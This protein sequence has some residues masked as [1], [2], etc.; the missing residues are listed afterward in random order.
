MEIPTTAKEKDMS[1]W[2]YTETELW[3]HGEDGIALYHVF[4]LVSFGRTVLAFA[5]A[6]RGE[7]KDADDPHDIAMRRSEDGGRSFAP[8]VT[9]IPSEGRRCLTNPTPLFDA[10]TGKLFLFYCENFGNH[11][12]ENYVIESADGGRTWSAP[13]ALTAELNA[14][15]APLAF[16]LFGPGH[17]TQLHGAYGGRLIVPV[18]H[19]RGTDVPKAERDY[20]AS[21]LLSDDHG[22]TWRQTAP[23]TGKAQHV[24]EARV[25]QT[26]DGS[27]LWA[28]RASGSTC[29]FCCRSTDGGESWSAP[30]PMPV[31][32][33]VGCDAGLAALSGKAGYEDLVVLSRI[34]RT[35]RR[36]DMELLYSK[37]GGRSFAGRMTLPTGDAMPGYSD[38]TVL[39]DEA[40]TLGL[41]HCRNNHV[42]FSRISLQTLT[43]GAYEG[44]KRSVWLW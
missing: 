44:T 32:P 9:L 1:L 38:L 17:G 30:A 4:G 31:S 42:L 16:H 8:S 10:Q 19:R 43:G 2:E 22:A 34:S 37:D 29:R 18:W 35:D 36:M 27:L 39:E 5:E 40:P 28:F 21:L 41:L 33:A 23:F 12:T 14:F 15:S 6:R 20:C 3:R 11:D 26:A 13:R 7:G 24:D 25:A